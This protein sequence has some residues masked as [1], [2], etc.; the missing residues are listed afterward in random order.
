MSAAKG[1]LSRAIGVPLTQSGRERKIG[2]MVSRGF[3]CLGLFLIL[4]LVAIL[5]KL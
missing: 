3:G 4:S 5:S 1:R 2:R